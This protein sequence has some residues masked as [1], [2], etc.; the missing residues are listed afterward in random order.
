MRANCELRR[1]EGRVSFF[2]VA[3]LAVALPVLAAPAGKRRAPEPA[4]ASA[5]AAADAPAGE[6][7]STPAESPP[8]AP[9]ETALESA[10]Q[11]DQ[12]AFYV[13][14]ELSAKRTD[15]RE[16]EALAINVTCEQEAYLY[17]LYEQADGK[18]F[19]IFPN[20]TQPN[21]KVPAKQTISVPAGD[22][23]FR[24]IIGKPF[25]KEVV[26]V[27]AS[28]QPIDP[29]SAAGQRS[30]RFNPVGKGTLKDT[31]EQVAALDPKDWAEVD[32]SLTTYS[33]DHPPLPHEKRR[34]GVFFGVSDYKYD[35]LRRQWAKK[36][37]KNPDEFGLNLNAGHSDAIAL[38]ETLGQVGH[39]DEYKVFVNE[40]A[41]RAQLEEI[42]TRWLPSVTKPGDTVFIGFSGH[43]GQIGDDN[44]DETND[45]KDE[46]LIPCDFIDPVILDEL[47]AQSQ[48]GQLD[49]ATAARVR[50][51]VG[52]AQA[53]GD[54]A[55]DALA[56]ETGVSDDLF[57]RWLQNLNG[58][59]VVVLLDTCH[60]GGFAEHEKGA[61][62]QRGFDFLEGELTRLKDIGQRDQ[63]M[64][65]AAMSSQV[66]RE[67]YDGSNGVLTAFLLESVKLS[68]GPVNLENG[69]QYCSEQIAK[70]FDIVNQ[71][72]QEAGK[73]KLEPHQPF[74]VNY[75]TQTIFLKP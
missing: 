30:Q 10:P 72:R 65:A 38:G 45:Q 44:G 5:P 49:A 69:Y 53:A 25:G 24:W 2:L 35:A 51:L 19:Q 62:E 39:L 1:L 27:F 75:C 74:F 12:P 22:D 57:G 40:Q 41:T 48:N 37:D 63:A 59:Q 33:K 50:H 8:A 58:R 42:V 11:N 64:L 32:L 17:V 67:L 34:I 68:N 3:L 56:R 31:E 55:Y 66:A 7:P 26:K 9:A 23:L 36:H 4:E 16:G 6:Q 54:N 14:A 43:G 18:L 29:L 15:F 46:V 21:N 28:K 61:A 60:S 73:E 13:N 71:K 20:K 47:Y 52:I 70:Y